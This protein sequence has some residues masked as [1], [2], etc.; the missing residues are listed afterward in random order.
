MILRNILPH[1]DKGRFQVTKTV[2]DE[3]VFRMPPLR[4][5]ELTPPYF[6]SGKSWDLGQAVAVMGTSQL[7]QKLN[8]EEVS[9]IT[10]FLRSLTGDQPQVRPVAVPG[11]L[12]ARD[13][14]R[15]AARREFGCAYG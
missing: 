10:A 6:Y 12:S 13:R 11:E 4:N 15:P 9:A 7:G 3:Y 2:S 8:N 1:A 14:R 5:I